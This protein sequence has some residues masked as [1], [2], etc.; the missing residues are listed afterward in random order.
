MG[1]VAIQV[2]FDGKVSIQIDFDGESSY[3][4]RL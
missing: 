2:D 1:K 4:D 3:T